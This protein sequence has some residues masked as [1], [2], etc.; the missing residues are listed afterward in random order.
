MMLLLAPVVEAGFNVELELPDKYNE[1]EPGEKV[2]FTSKLLNLQNKRRL[3]VTLV[4]TLHDA[5]D[6][7][8]ASRSE[9]V[10]IETQASFVGNLKTPSHL[11]DGSYTLRVTV[12]SPFGTTNADE[13]L[14]VKA[15][16]KEE[17]PKPQVITREVV[18]IVQAMPVPEPEAPE[19]EEKKMHSSVGFAIALLLSLLLL[20]ELQVIKRFIDRQRVQHKVEKFLK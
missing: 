2:W 3:D 13:S 19:I 15:P 7:R 16:P 9:T 11:E 4:Y 18:K 20:K 14:Y 6:R 10:A 5:N 17:P 8:L 12:K 1:I